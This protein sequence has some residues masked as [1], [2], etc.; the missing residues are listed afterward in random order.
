MNFFNSFKVAIF[1]YT[2][3]NCPAKFFC[4]VQEN[5]VIMHRID[6]L[7]LPSGREKYRVG[8]TY[9]KSVTRCF[10]DWLIEYYHHRLCTKDKCR[11]DATGMLNTYSRCVL[12]RLT[13]PSTHTFGCISNPLRGYHLFVST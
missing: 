9:W 2:M 10:V 11:V 3:N 6:R 13:M 5:C 4:E 1:V 8:T 12:R 7:R